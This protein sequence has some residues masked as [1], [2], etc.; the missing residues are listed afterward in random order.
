MVILNRDLAFSPRQLGVYFRLVLS[1]STTET[2]IL[3]SGYCQL[4][5]R[6]RA[7]TLIE[8]LVVI[9]IIAILAA[10]LLPALASAK[11]KTQ[12]L[13]CINNLKQ[14]TMAYFMYQ[15]DFGKAVAYGE[16]STLWM[17]TLIQYHSQVANV[18]LCPVAADR[19]KTA[20]T[21]QGN[22]AMPWRWGVENPL[23][24]LGSYAINSWLYTFEGAS[25]WDAEKDKYFLNETAIKQPSQT[26]AF[27]DAN[28]PDTWPDLNSTPPTDL[29][30]GDVGTSLGR[31]CLARHPLK[32][33]AVT[34][35]NRPV[36][37][38]INAGYADGHAA[39]LQLQNIKSVIWHRKYV[40]VSDPWRTS[41]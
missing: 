35:A 39:R 34:A 26:P 18:R 13:K 3:R 4:P 31:I 27:M 11:Q 15:Q 38:A 7:F 19:G 33:N 24:D 16:V 22:A 2:A 29:F 20:G 10:M 36:P 28:W 32:R 8:L 17:K 41:P 9:A 12:S 40:P 23:L 21:G 37:G 6:R 25:Q 30:A 14:T 5:K 1:Q